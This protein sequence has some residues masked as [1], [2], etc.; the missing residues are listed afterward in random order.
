M[1]LLEKLHSRIWDEI[2]RS[3]GIMFDTG[4]EPRIKAIIREVLGEAVKD[5][6][7]CEKCKWQA[8]GGGKCRALESDLCPKDEWK[9]EK[10]KG[11][12]T[13]DKE[14]EHNAF[15]RVTKEKQE[16]EAD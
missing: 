16:N 13:K 8:T 5:F 1:S 14:W 7:S 4:E 2:C 3:E 10:F 6:P 12:D 15:L 11:L 9:E